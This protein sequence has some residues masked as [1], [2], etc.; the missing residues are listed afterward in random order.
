MLVHGSISWYDLPYPQSHLH[1]DNLYVNL[2]LN[3]LNAVLFDLRARTRFY[4][5]NICTSKALNCDRITLAMK[6][7]IV[8]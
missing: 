6:L 5:H 4:V 2:L 3:A 8:A 1:R 7:I